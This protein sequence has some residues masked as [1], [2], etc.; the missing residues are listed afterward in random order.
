MNCSLPAFSVHGIFQDGILESVAISFSKGVSIRGSH[1]IEALSFRRLLSNSI[2]EKVIQ[3]NIREFIEGIMTAAMYMMLTR[4][5][6]SSVG[7]ESAYNA[8]DPG[9]IPESGR[10]TGEGIGYPLQ[11]S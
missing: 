8:G 2:L 3:H 5:P 10:S 6:G 11:Y 7:K 4:F 9:S 1:F